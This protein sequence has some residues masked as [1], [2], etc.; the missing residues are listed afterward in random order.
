LLRQS[1]YAK[2]KKAAEM[3]FMYTETFLSSVSL[4]SEMEQAVIQLFESG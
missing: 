1:G 3:Y 2:T 4:S